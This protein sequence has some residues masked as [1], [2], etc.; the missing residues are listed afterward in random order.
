MADPTLIVEFAPT[1]TPKDTT[2]TWVDI[3]SYCRGFWC[4]RGRPSE[5]DRME[6]GEGA[7]Y[8]DNT[9]QIFDPTYTGGTYYG[10]LKPNKRLRIRA[11][12]GVTTTYPVFSG[13]V[14][15]WPR[16]Y[17]GKRDA[18]AAVP[19]TDAFRA[20][21]LDKLT[22][23]FSSEASGTR[24]ANTLDAMAWPSGATWR[25][26]DT[27]QSTLQ[28]STLA[29]SGLEHL[30]LCAASELG[31]FF[32]SRDGKATFIDRAA[33]LLTLLDTAL[34]WGNGAGQKPY[35]DISFA[36]PDYSIWNPISVSAP[37]LTTQTASDSAAD[38]DNFSRLYELST[39][40]STT[41]QM[42]DL[43]NALLAKYKSSASRVD[44]LVVKGESNTWGSV[45][46]REIGDLIRVS[47]TPTGGSVVEQDSI[48][49]GV[50]FDA[51]P[52]TG[53][54]V[55]WSLSPS[56]GAQD[57]LIV[58]DAVNGILGSNRLAY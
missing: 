34:T 14:K 42:S 7:V 2:P 8:L 31:L 45:L 37:S 51:T 38:D 11:T 24:V 16:I 46:G 35:H 29:G 10:N 21:N 13:L 5:L 36:D 15:A 12:D 40:L 9:S 49:Q 20:W 32:V 55:T 33:L 48:I 17:P 26:I 25:D 43:A 44:R 41:N 58:G 50:R 6:G 54:Q 1:N 3:T 56:D 52:A 18:V 28:A 39:I 57:Y 47:H 23:S 22:S 4:K 30:L 19:L 27:G 53:W